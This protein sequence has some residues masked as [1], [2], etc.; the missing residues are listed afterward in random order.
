MKYLQIV[1]PAFLALTSA[2]NSRAT[3]TLLGPAKI[4]ALDAGIPKP[5]FDAMVPGPMDAMVIVPPD[6]GI[7]PDAAV[8]VDTGVVF[9]D[10]GTPPVRQMVNYQLTGSPGP[11]N[12]VNN[13]PLDLVA[14]VAP[15]ATRGDLTH[16]MPARTPTMLPAV[17]SGRSNQILISAHSPQGNSSASIWVGVPENSNLTLPDVM[18]IG[19]NRAGLDQVPLQPT[20]GFPTILDG[21][22]WQ[23]FTAMSRLDFRGQIYF[24]IENSRNPVFYLNGP[25]LRLLPATAQLRDAKLIRARPL[26]GAQAQRAQ[27]LIGRYNRKLREKLEA[28]KLSLPKTPSPKQH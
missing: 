8:P 5:S 2:C 25:E 11:E 14:A 9:P 26:L 10:A 3:T 6:S 13:P 17:R 27:S 4:S 23:Q 19:V 16:W 21:I 28:P 1:L 22:Q 20:E 7:H 12:Y 24:Y 18:L 15:I